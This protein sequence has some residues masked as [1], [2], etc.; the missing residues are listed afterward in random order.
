[1][2]VI[3]VSTDL[4]AFHTPQRRR[5]ACELLI[6]GALSGAFLTLFPRRPIGVDLSLALFALC[7]VWLNADFT[8]TQLWG[9]CPISAESPN[10]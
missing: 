8:R 9:Q 6:L 3:S 5:V 10:G 4:G 2:R 7:L 1:M